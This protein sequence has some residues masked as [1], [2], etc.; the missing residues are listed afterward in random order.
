MCRHSIQFSANNKEKF[1]ANSA[2]SARRFRRAH[3]A[4]QRVEQAAFPGE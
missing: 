2:L 3:G 1:F 4:D